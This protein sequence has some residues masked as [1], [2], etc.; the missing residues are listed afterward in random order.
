MEDIA[1]A[2]GLLGL[3]T[4][5]AW[6]LRWVVTTMVELRKMT[7]G[8]STLGWALGQIRSDPSGQGSLAGGRRR[9][10]PGSG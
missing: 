5:A 3:V 6:L 8:L 1:V 9:R 2:A 10:M 7:T 4:L